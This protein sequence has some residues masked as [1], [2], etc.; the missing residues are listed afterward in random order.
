MTEA[1][2]KKDRTSLFTCSLKEFD[3]YIKGLEQQLEQA[4]NQSK[5][6]WE[7][8]LQTE[9]KFCKILK[10]KRDYIESII[11]IQNHPEA[12]EYLADTLK[13]KKEKLQNFNVSSLDLLEHWLETGEIL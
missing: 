3:P 10:I 7:S 11:Q 8:E 12:A 1:S 2:F 5:L 13:E 9:I 6:D 4:R